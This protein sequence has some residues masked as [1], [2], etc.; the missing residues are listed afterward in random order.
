MYEINS[1]GHVVQDVN[2]MGS[3]TAWYQALPDIWK[4]FKQ[5]IVFPRIQALI[6][7]NEF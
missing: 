4:A 5:E 3:W 2:P 1:H 7:T 6:D